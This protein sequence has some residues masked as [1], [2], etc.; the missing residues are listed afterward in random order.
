V[1]GEGGILRLSDGTRFMKDYSPDMMELAPR[2]IVARAIDHV[3]KKTGESCVYID[4]THKEPDFIKQRFPNIYKTC[5]EKGID[6]TTQFIPVVPAAHYTGGGVLVDEFGKSDILNLYAIGETSYTGLHGANRLASNSL[7][8]AVVFA[9]L[10]VKS[11]K[12]EW[13]SATYKE[14]DI[15]DWK[16]G[17]VFD[18]EEWVIIS[19][20]YR[21]LRQLMWNYAGIVR[22][23]FRLTRALVRIMDIFE[24]VNDFYRQNPVR[25]SVLDLRNMVY[26]AWLIVR[27]ALSRTESRG[28]HFNTDHPETL[29]GEPVDTVF[30]SSKWT[31]DEHVL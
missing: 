31:K 26:V 29:P 9:H 24:E 18:H 19:H 2:D 25:T 30:R 6:I 22:S 16:D 21:A 23:D 15:P 8:E 10:A 1:R 12:A 14:P 3:L 28:L 20:N 11:I 7:L 27:S 17:S 5:L 13:N 4:L